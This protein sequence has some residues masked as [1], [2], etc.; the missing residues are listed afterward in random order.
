MIKSL[1]QI[2]DKLTDFIFSEKFE[3]IMFQAIMIQFVLVV[4]AQLYLKFKGN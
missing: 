2:I 1:L 4:I 3:K